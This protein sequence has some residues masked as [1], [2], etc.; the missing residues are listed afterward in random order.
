MRCIKSFGILVIVVLSALL[1]AP[2]AAARAEDASPLLLKREWVVTLS[3]SELQ[4]AYG[5]PNKR[6]QYG[7]LDLN[8]G[9]LRLRHSGSADFGTALLLLPAFWSDGVYYQ[10]ADPGAPLTQAWREEGSTL[11]L[12]LTAAAHGLAVSTVVQVAPPDNG[13]ITAQVA[14]TIT[15]D[16]PIDSRP[17][18]AFKPIL[19]TSRHAGPADWA[20]QSAFIQNRVIPL[21]AADW[22]APSQPAL[23]ATLFGL[24]GGI[25][26][27]KAG[28]PTVQVTLSEPFP[29]TGRI[30]P[31]A[32]GDNVSLWAASDAILRAY[33]YQVSVSGNNTV[34][35]AFVPW[36][37]RL[38]K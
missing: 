28:A 26:D 33:Q 1:P 5:T 35:C 16:A 32:P 10:G 17:G 34:P 27:G 36:V 2:A 29:V 13:V 15:G 24:L 7:A 14:N 8:S 18:E 37:W 21:P 19:L 3:G 23:S 12:T 22:I 11:V 20:A 4:F 31:A 6:T 9:F 25:P 30:N 38:K